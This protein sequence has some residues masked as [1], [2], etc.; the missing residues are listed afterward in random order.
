MNYHSDLVEEIETKP[1]RGIS[2]GHTT[3][4]PHHLTQTHGFNPNGTSS[5][6]G[7]GFKQAEAAANLFK[8]EADSDD[9]KG[10]S[11]KRHQRFNSNPLRAP[12]LLKN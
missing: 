11:N 4:A 8:N 2:L 9:T 3:R 5:G 10:Y 6:G 7:F 12:P 1:K